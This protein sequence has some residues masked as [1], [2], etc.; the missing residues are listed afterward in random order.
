MRQILLCE[1][2]RLETLGG[3]WVVRDIPPVWR[4]VGSAGTRQADLARGTCAWRR[5]SGWRVVHFLSV[6]TTCCPVRFWALT[7][8][9]PRRLPVSHSST[10][11]QMTKTWAKFRSVSDSS[12]WVS[13]LIGTSYSL[14]KIL[15]SVTTKARFGSST[16]WSQ[17]K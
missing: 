17:K 8:I 12:A 4:R 6:S 2:D 14:K 15:G 9:G 5:M 11:L 13:S 7:T 1:A 3:V 16:H 10:L